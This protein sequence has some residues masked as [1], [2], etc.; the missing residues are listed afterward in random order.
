M[1]NRANQLAE[2]IE[3]LSREV[4]DEVNRTRGMLP[5]KWDW[6]PG[7]LCFVRRREGVYQDVIESV[8][9]EGMATVKVKAQSH[10]ISTAYLFDTEAAA[11]KH[12][13]M[14]CV[15]KRLAGITPRRRYR[16]DGRF[17]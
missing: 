10:S 1:S 7:D 17:L 9:A 6:K 15:D 5:C 14:D 12:S 3:A 13:F 2:Q 8:D 4:C 11:Q 16:D